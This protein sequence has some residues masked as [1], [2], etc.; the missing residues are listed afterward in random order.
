MSK[1]RFVPVDFSLKQKFVL[2][3]WS[4]EKYRNKDGIIADGSI[5]SGKTT[6]MSLSFV[7]WAMA[8]FDGEN[9]ALCGKTIQSLFTRWCFQRTGKPAL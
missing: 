9:F 5:R 4:C 8:T 3:W 7:E 1:N 2:T 6:V